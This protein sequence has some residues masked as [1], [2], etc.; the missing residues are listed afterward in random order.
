MQNLVCC[1]G[2]G[3]K[4]LA[5]LTSV[6]FSFAT[7]AQAQRLPGGVHP[8]HYE[9]TLMPD[10]KAATFTGDESIDVVLDK[11]SKAITLNALEIHFGGV[12]ADGQTAKISLDA[13]KEQATFTFPNALLAGNATLH[14]VYSGILNSELRGF[15]LSKTAQRNYAV[16]QFEPTDARRAFPSFDEPAMKASYSVTLVV[17][18]GDTA[19]SNTNIISDTPGPIAGKHTIQFAPTPK[20]ST[21]LVAFLVGDFKCVSGESDGVPIRACA[22][23]DKV[24]FAQFAVTTAEF[25]L[26]YYDNYFGIKYPMP[27]LDMIAL[28]DFEAGAMENFGAITYRE[29]AMLVDEKTATLDAKKNVAIDIAH[30]MAHQWFGDMVTMQWWDNLWL[31]EGFA[32]W[33]ETK[34]VAAWKPEWHLDEDEAD[35]L[36]EAMNYDAQST[37]HP[38]RMPSETRGDINELFDGISYGKAGSIISM[39]EHYLGKETFQRGVQDYLKAHMYGNATAE[40]FWKAQK[41][42]SKKPVDKIMKSFVVQA[43]VP[44]L[45]FEQDGKDKVKV[46]QQRFYLSLSPDDKPAAQAWVVPVCFLDA[47]SAPQCDLLSGEKKKLKEPPSP[48][49]LYGNAG[50]RGY[51][52]SAYSAEAY[53]QIV[54]NAESKLTPGERIGLVGD[55]WALM[56]AGLS[57]AASYLDLLN[58]VAHDSSPAVLRSAL[59]GEAVIRNRIATD[60]EREQLSAWMRQVFD[61]IYKALPPA[62]KD[63]SPDALEMRALLFSVLGEQKD[64]TVVAEAREIVAKYMA[65]PTSVESSLGQSAVYVT[66]INSDATNG[67][68]ALYDAILKRSQTETDP[69]LQSEALFSLAEFRD[70]TLVQRTLDYVAEGKV[71][72]QDSWI[73]LITEMEDRDTRDQAWA[74]MKAHWDK[75]SAQLTESS[76]GDVV[77][78]VGG[79][80][81]EERRTEVTQFFAGIKVDAASRAMKQ[82]V[83]NIDGCILLRKTQ[84]PSLQAW[85][86]GNAPTQ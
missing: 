39:V 7:G 12:T 78:S 31:N 69:D 2:L 37:T 61:P 10:L 63:D 83:N 45:Q 75:I 1:R 32:T 70:P 27:K 59:D 71:R 73:V 25:V 8:E 3:W 58:A 13:N 41:A 62:A 77:E 53:K 55:Q 74:Y 57:S 68:A 84:G 43:G 51:Y 28:P 16:S 19:I 47:E 65:D 80:C 35:T 22:T 49:F 79:F 18:D 81:T 50:G 67:D 9:L 72:N 42:A 86:A 38:I 85:L 33:M 46:S 48:P 26:H 5:M 23:P 34:A 36:D 14:I 15:Y 60:A 44:L 52:R 30:E 64:P 17:D 11:P 20:M 40:D 82:A 24:Q 56:R 4:R 29:T 21:Y 76:G 54:N 6:V 66:I